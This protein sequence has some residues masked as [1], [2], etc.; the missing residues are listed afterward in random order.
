MMQDREGMKS[1]KC[2]DLLYSVLSLGC[3]IRLIRLASHEEPQI[4]AD[5]SLLR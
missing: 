2:P 3:L 5:A 4:F 1:P